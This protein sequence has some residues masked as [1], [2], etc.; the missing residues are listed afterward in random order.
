M[1]AAGGSQWGEIGE[2]GLVG[3]TD[4][5]GAPSEKTGEQGGAK[6]SQGPRIP[7]GA[8]FEAHRKQGGAK[9]LE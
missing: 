2:Q 8:L 7:R 3:A 6:R 4:D 1:A 9:P 5:I